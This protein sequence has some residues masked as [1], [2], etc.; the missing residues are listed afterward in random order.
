M[1]CACCSLNLTL[2][3][4]EKSCGKAIIF[5]WNHSKHIC[6]IMGPTKR[7]N[8]LLK[9]VPSLTVKPLFN[10]RWENQIKSVIIIYQAPKIRS[11]LYEI[12]MLKVLNLKI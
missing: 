9:H 11:T 10:T 6:P 2:S 3:G 7:W 4:M 8:V 1:P 5:F 12:P